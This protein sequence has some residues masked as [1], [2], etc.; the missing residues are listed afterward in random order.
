[1]FGR[2]STCVRPLKSLRAAT[3]PVFG[4]YSTCVR[5]LQS[6]RS[7]A[8][9]P[10]FGRYSTPAPG[11][12][13]FHEETGTSNA[14]TDSPRRGDRNKSDHVKNR[15]TAAV[16]MGGRRRRRWAV[17]D[18]VKRVGEDSIGYPRM[19]ASGES[20]TTMHRL[21][22]A[23]GSHPIPTPGD[24]N[25]WFLRLLV[26]EIVGVDWFCRWTIIEVIPIIASAIYRKTWSSNCDIN[27]I[28][29]K[30]FPRLCSSFRTLEHCSAVSFSGDFPSFPVGVLLVQGN[31]GSTAGRG[32]N[33]AGGA[34]GG[35]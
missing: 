11:S 24:P 34:P 2:Y 21:L 13:Q 28:L 31:P 29:S 20:L 26:W 30:Y 8:T 17:G 18:G 6:L 1:M 33:P 9:V 4:R 35:G 14:Q 23:L 3:V 12:D 27:S 16:A 22:H 19:S 15:A 10:A 7:A 32:F 25:R 5:P